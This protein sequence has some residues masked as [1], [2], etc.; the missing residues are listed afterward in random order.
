MDVGHLGGVR[1]YRVD[2]DHRAARILGD[3]VEYDAGTRKAL[4]HP[5]VLPDEHRYLGVFELAAGVSTVEVG[6][7]PRLTGLF[8]REC[9]RPVVRS[10]QLEEGD[11]VC[12]PE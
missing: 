10:K 1:Q 9:V 4:R 5:W 6:V 11:A 12:T 8:L 7:D 3:F 2:H